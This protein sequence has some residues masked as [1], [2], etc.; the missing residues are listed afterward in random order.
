ME[1][2]CSPETLVLKSPRHHGHLHRRENLESQTT[3]FTFNSIATTTRLFAAG[4]MHTTRHDK[5]IV[6]CL[7]SPGVYWQFVNKG[8]LRFL[9]HF[10]FGI[11]K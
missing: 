4:L 11:W 3:K 7:H 9:S 5:D 1:A 10:R 2:V 8:K 6:H